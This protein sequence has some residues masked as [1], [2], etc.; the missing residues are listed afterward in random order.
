MHSHVHSPTPTH[1]TVQSLHCRRSKGWGTFHAG[2]GERTSVTVLAWPGE[3]NTLRCPSE[4]VFLFSASICASPFGEVPAV[5]LPVKGRA[6][7][8]HIFLPRVLLMHGEEEL[9]Q[10]K[11]SGHLFR[12]Y[13]IIKRHVHYLSVWFLARLP[14]VPLWLDKTLCPAMQEQQLYKRPL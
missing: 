7:P 12:A 1:R 5:V 6:P 9:F 8:S 11:L 2:H 4:G 10:H 14:L 13:F 3:S